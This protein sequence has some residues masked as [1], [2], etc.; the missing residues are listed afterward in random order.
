MLFEWSQVC[1][2]QVDRFTYRLDICVPK[3]IQDDF[4]KGGNGEYWSCVS[5]NL[6]PFTDSYSSIQHPHGFRL[7]HVPMADHVETGHEE[8][9]ETGALHCHVFGMLQNLDHPPQL[10]V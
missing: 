1:G 5:K 8:V 9:G 10:D 2:D 4:K 3:G 7:R 6:L